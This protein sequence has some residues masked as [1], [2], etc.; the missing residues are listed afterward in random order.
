MFIINSDNRSKQ[1]FVLSDSTLGVLRVFNFLF[2]PV[3]YAKM[4]LTYL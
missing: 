2:V 4:L 1:Y 3:K